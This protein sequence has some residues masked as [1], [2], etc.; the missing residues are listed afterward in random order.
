M[1]AR[2]WSWTDR[3]IGLSVFFGTVCLMLQVAVIL[4]DVVGRYFGSPLTGARDI[5]QM[6][7]AIVVFGGMALCDR[8]GGHISVDV[9]EN[10]LPAPLIRLG[11]IVS[12]L[13]GAVVFFGI[14]WTVWE[15]AALSRM[16]NLATNII[17]LP[18]A[19]FQYAV[20]VMSLITAIAMLLRAAEAIISGTHSPHE[21][22]G[23]I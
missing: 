20:V 15:S 2:L 3:L 8:I 7:M 22:E 17:Y 11:D 19:W 21:Q 4:V 1:L 13:L 14:A 23:R 16:L 5:T 9:F 18:K 10:I 6:S 12:P